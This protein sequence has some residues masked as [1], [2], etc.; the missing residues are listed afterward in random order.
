MGSSFPVSDEGS[1]AWLGC[2]GLRRVLWARD[3]L[4]SWTGLLRTL[5]ERFESNP[6]TIVRWMTTARPRD[7]G[8]IAQIIA[9]HAA[10]G[11]AMGRHLMQTSARHVDVMAER[12]RVLGVQR[13]ALMGGLSIKLEP[14]LSDETR[15]NLVAP[16]GDALSG[17]LR[18]ARGAVEGAAATPAT[19]PQ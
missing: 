16:R 11:D 1:G 13:L 10:Q 9:D 15:N 8:T 3:G 6:H 17:A 12:L 2:E 5:F 14:F 19:W 7:F 18:L 4:I